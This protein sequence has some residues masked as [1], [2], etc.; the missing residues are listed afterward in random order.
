[1]ELILNDSVRQRWLNVRRRSDAV[2]WVVYLLMWRSAII[3][4]L[5]AGIRLGSVRERSYDQSRVRVWLSLLFG[6]SVELAPGKRGARPTRIFPGE[7]CEST[8]ITGVTVSACRNPNA[9]CVHHA[10]RGSQRSCCRS[11]AEKTI[12]WCCGSGP[13]NS[14]S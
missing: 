11:S 7:N 2:K 9:I 3:F 6:F 10:N 12:H 8:R 14:K 1:M 4:G 5:W 13:A